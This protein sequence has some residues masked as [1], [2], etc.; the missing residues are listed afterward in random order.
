MQVQESGQMQ[1]QMQEQV[2]EWDQDAGLWWGV[3]EISGGNPASW[4]W[5]LEFWA[6]FLA[7]YC[8]K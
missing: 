8:G 2:Q 4:S 7:V 6:T 1:E 3:G 5:R